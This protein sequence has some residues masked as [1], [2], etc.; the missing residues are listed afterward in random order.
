MIKA[1][2]FDLDGTLLDRA[3]SLIHFAEQQHQRFHNV[4]GKIPKSIYVRD[5]AAL[6]SNG[7]VWKDEV[8]RQLLER[9]KITAVSW[10]TMLQDY[11]DNLAMSCVGFPGLV[12]MLAELQSRGYAM[13]MVTNG[14]SPFQERNISALKI[15]PFFSTILVSEAVGLRKPDSAIFR[16]ALSDLNTAAIESVF[17]G[18]SPKSDIEGAQQIGMKTIWKHN[19]EW[20]SCDFADAVCKDLAGLPKIIQGL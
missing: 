9:H 8:Y 12:P 11:V 13:G 10:E 19:S 2:L 4:L 18:D 3:R 15:Q 16:R 14:R 5:F 7:R 20:K 17:V 6:D 1:V